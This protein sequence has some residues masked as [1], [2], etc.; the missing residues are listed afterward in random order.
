MESIVLAVVRREGAISVENII[1][2]TGFK[3]DDVI[4]TLNV[5]EMRG[6]L[7][8]ISNTENTSLCNTC[9]L[10][11]LCKRKEHINGTN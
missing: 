9:P 8:F 11:K 7:T 10:N 5:L 3:R 4:K 2:K 1:R 6:K